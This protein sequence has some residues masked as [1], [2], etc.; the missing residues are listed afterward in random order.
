MSRTDDD[1]GPP[2]VLPRELGKDLLAASVRSG[3]AGPDR[4]RAHS[5]LVVRRLTEVWQRALMTTGLGE[6]PTGEPDG[7]VQGPPGVVLA[8]VGSLARGDAGPASDVDLLLLHEGRRLPVDRLG[9]L[10]EALWYPLWD[11]GLR[12]DHS[13]RT[14]AQ[15]REVAAGDLAAAVGL[16]DVALVAGDSSLVS[17]ARTV[18]LA[19]WR[20]S[21]RR[22]L[23]QVLDSLAE[24][25]QRHGDL[26]Y[27]LEP[28]L[29]ESRGGL[30][31]VTTLR[32]MAA[33]WLTD[34][35]H[36][37]D[38]EA[39]HAFLL[40]AR[41]ALQMVTGRPGDRLGLA[42]QD[43]VAAVLGFA[44]ADSLLARVSE[45]GRTIAHAVDTTVRRARQS[46]PQRRWRPGPR[47]PSLRP[48][49]HGLVEHDGELVLGAGTSPADDPALALRAAATA[50]RAGLPLSPVTTENLGA[51][52]APLPE[53]WPAAARE[54]FVEL[55]A[56]GEALPGVWESLD[57]EG[58]VVRW[59]PEWA[60]VRNR[61]QRNA[62]H[63]WTV[64]RHQV[65]T[66]VEANRFL[67]EVSRPDLLLL[68]CLLHDLGKR[69]GAMDHA[70]VGAP[71]ARGVAERIGLAPGDVAVVER[72][73]AE[74]LTL[75]DLA[76]RRD[77][78]DPSTVE[79][80]VVAVDGR[81]D[82]LTLLRALTE[83][84]ALAAGPAAWS[85]WRARLVDDLVARA[86]ALLRGEAA[87]GP[88]P[89]TDAEAALVAEARADGA[90][91]FSVSE[92]EGLLAVTVVAPDRGGL[93]ADIAGVLAVHRLGVRSALVRTLAGTAVDTWWVEP[94]GEVPDPAVLRVSLQRLENGDTTV[95]ERL[96]RRDASA[97]LRRPAHDRPAVVV[98]PDAS[99]TATVLE[100][101]SQDRPGLLAGLG[102][103]LLTHGVD[104]RSA[105]VATHAG[106]AVDVLYVVESSTGEPLSPPRVGEVVAALVEAADPELAAS[107]GG[108]G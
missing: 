105:H 14:I 79:A 13:V 73:V 89:L 40:D 106:Q 61:P 86:R 84:D 24:R 44:D 72:L 58:L 1:H 4:R 22:R 92:L 31:D 29:K 81:A 41:D 19:D 15:C 88:A 94:S 32:A 23:P 66:C 21:A 68:A 51:S 34:R 8:M 12:L 70:R 42:D 78:D 11:A 35:P 27:L 107:T 47:R 82:V 33:S 80:L 16:L 55:L 102:R 52:G 17:H 95:L 2:G 25:A 77:P 75:V 43:A 39:G 71:L 53:P 26:A 85:P 76:T 90:S 97:R 60:G 3:L 46:L 62:V 91:R 49:G 56:S 83:A 108:Q 5:A 100:V 9:E 57:L 87:P 103:A 64:D 101:R 28:D 93:F 96:A 36:S 10:A 20:A 6:A 50:A 65:Q 7:D 37:A 45:T 99:E 104:I 63:R 38:I 48:L 30:R 74:H 67:R 18:L 59:L 54:A 69:A 98:V